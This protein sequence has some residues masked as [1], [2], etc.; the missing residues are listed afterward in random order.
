MDH[1]S[2]YFLRCTS[3][4]LSLMLS[5]ERKQRNRFTIKFVPDY[6]LRAVL[7]DLSGIIDSCMSRQTI[8]KHFPSICV[9]SFAILIQ[10]EPKSKIF[11]NR[12]IDEGSG[13]GVSQVGTVGVS[14]LRPGRAARF[15]KPLPHL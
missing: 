6:I 10:S 12:F 5:H 13:A 14:M 9:L 2:T 8:Q 7:A 3:R 15:P 11:N 1:I 4:K